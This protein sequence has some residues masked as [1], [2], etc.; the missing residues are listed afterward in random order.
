[1]YKHKGFEITEL[2]KLT[3]AFWFLAKLCVLKLVINVVAYWYLYIPK[4]DD[5]IK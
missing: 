3:N 2:N 1:M 5:G 4:I